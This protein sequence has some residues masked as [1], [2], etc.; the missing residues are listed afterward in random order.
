VVIAVVAAVLVALFLIWRVDNARVVQ[1]AYSYCSSNDPRL[2][3]GLGAAAEPVEAQVR[4][5][6]GQEERF[7]NLETE[8]SH[9]LIRGRGRPT[10]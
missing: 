10:R 1:T 7:S 6:D 5:I 8:R 3:F 4:W 2:H 9:V